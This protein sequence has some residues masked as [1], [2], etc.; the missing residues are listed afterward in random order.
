MAHVL[1][2]NLRVLRV[3]WMAWRARERNPGFHRDK[4]DGAPLHPAVSPPVGGVCGWD[5]QAGLVA[6][7]GEQAV[8][9]ALEYRVVGAAALRV[10]A[11]PP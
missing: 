3:I 6:L 7:D 9:S 1:Q 4:L 10:G 11:H 5:V 2:F 8:G